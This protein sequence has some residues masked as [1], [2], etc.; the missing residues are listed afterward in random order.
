[1]ESTKYETATKQEQAFIDLVKHSNLFLD[2]LITQL[3]VAKTLPDKTL[4]DMTIDNVISS[5][6]DLKELN[7]QMALEF[8]CWKE[9]KK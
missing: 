4:Q 6:N 7:K 8:I 9:A 2:D 3:N 5:A 1:M